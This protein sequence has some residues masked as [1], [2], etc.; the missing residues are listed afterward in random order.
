MSGRSKCHAGVTLSNRAESLFAPVLTGYS[1]KDESSAETRDNGKVQTNVCTKTKGARVKAR[2]SINYRAVE[3][4]DRGHMGRVSCTP[5][6]PEPNHERG[7]H[8][9]STRG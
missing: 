3:N 7:S 6:P 5:G 9:S 8:E 4:P 2:T 1:G